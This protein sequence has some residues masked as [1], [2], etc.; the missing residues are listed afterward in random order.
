M[1]DWRLWLYPELRHASERDRDRIW[2]LAKEESF[3]AA[4]SMLM[5]AGVVVAAF[6]VRYAD[7]RS[8][9]GN[10]FLG[11]AADFIV[12]GIVLIVIAGPAYLRRTKRG[13]AGALKHRRQ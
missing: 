8:L 5:I 4:E 9:L 7:F 10:A 12:T 1:T 2:H 11:F 3:S 13:L 6:V